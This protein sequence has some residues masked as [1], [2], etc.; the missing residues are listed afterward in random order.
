MRVVLLAAGPFAET[1]RPMVEA[2]LRCGAHYLDVSGEVPV[3]E[4]LVGR[5]AEARHRRIMMMPATGFDVV[6]SDCLAAHVA[7][8]LPGATRLA[9]ASPP[10]RSRRR[11]SVKTIVE[12]TTVVVRR[13]GAIIAVMPDATER[14]FD[15][16]NGSA[17]S[18]NVT[19]GDVATAY[20]TTAFRTSRCTSRRPPPCAACSPPIACSHRC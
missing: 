16:G 10:S 8:R 2:C 19:W 4:A 13:D 14:E 11:G 6:T 15:Y 7:A 1:S 18:I 3:I 17:A 12:Y 9:I 5:S 20:Y